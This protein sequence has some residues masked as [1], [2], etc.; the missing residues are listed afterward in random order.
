MTTKNWQHVEPIDAVVFDCDGTLSVL[1]GIDE[2]AR[3]NG[4]GDMVE[5]LTAHAMSKAG[6]S[7]E[8]YHARLHLV[9]P[10]LE[11]VIAAGQQYFKQQVPHVSEVIQLLQR[12]N[13]HVYIVS[14]GLH[15][16]VEY[17]GELLNVP[18]KN[19][20]AVNIHFDSDR[21]YID[22]DRTSPLIN[23]HGKREIITQLK[24]RHPRI[25]HVGDGLNDYVV[26]DLVTRFIGFGGV[27]YRE[28]IAKGCEYYIK[29]ASMAPLLPL[30]LTKE[31]CDS[32]TFEERELYHR[33]LTAIHNLEVLIR[34]EN[35]QQPAE[36]DISMTA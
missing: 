10:K 33:G 17:F 27:F 20:Y 9:Q 16:S 22:F 2:L 7:E 19:I 18:R 4:V 25:M 5:S 30:T 14:A 29:A 11:Q 12:L 26:Y 6:I 1:E 32:L 8:M 3:S 23:S 15:P 13:K 21:K 34:S 36:K 24:Q 35:T 31:E 28:N